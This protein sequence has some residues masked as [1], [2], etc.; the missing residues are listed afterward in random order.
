MKCG[1][2]SA[3]IQDILTKYDTK[4]KKQT[5]IMAERAKF[6]Y[7]ES[8][9]VGGHHIEFREISISEEQTTAAT[10]RWLSA[11]LGSI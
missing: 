2:Y 7:H 9:D 1:S 4:V 11:V 10:E 3:I 5:A 6:T 8:K